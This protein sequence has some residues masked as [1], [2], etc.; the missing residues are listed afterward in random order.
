MTNKKLIQRPVAIALIRILLLSIFPLGAFA[1]EGT[2]GSTEATDAADTADTVTSVTPLNLYDSGI[3]AF[4]RY[5][6]TKWGAYQIFP[7]TSLYIDW[8]FPDGSEPYLNG[9]S[10]Y[11]DATFNYPHYMEINGEPAYCIFPGVDA[12][13]LTYSDEQALDTWEN[14]FS[15]AQRQAIGLIVALGYGA[16]D[17]TADPNDNMPSVLNWDANKTYQVQKYMATQILIWEIIVQDRSATY[18]YTLNNSRIWDSFYKA[19]SASYAWPTMLKV[20]NEIL[21]QMQRSTAVPSF[22]S[23]ASGTAPTVELQYNASA[24]QYEASLTDTNGVLASYDFSTSAA[25]ISFTKNGSILTVAAT[26]AAAQTLQKAPVTASAVGPSV[27]ADPDREAIV[28]SAAYGQP[29]VTAAETDPVTAYIRLTAEPTGTA[30]IKKVSSDGDVEGYC[31]KIYQWDEDKSWYGKTDSDGNVFVTDENY[32]AGTASYS[33]DGMT[34]GEYTFLEVLSR[35][36]AGNVFPDSWTITVTDPS[37]NTVYNKTFTS[38]IA[39]DPNGDARLGVTE[40]KIAITGLTG[41]GKMSMTIHNAP[42]T[43]ELEILKTSSSGSVSGFEFLVEGNGF[44]QTVTSDDSGKILLDGLIP[45]TYTVTEILPD[46]SPYYCTTENPQ[47]VTVEYGTLATVTFNNELKQW[48]VTVS[49]KDSATG[50][51]QAD[52]TLDGAVYG[53]YKDGI[54][55]KEYTVKNGTFTTDPWPCGT[56]YTLKEITP[57]VG[58]QLSTR[59]YKLDAYSA[60]EKSTGT[61]TTSK[62]TVFETVIKGCFQITKRTLNPVSGAT[63]PEAGAEFR[64]YLK[65]AGSYDASDDLCRGTMT[66]GEDGVAISRNLPYG[67]YIVEQTAGAEGTD[68]AA[69]FEVTVSEQGKTYEYTIDNPYWTGSVAIVKYETGTTTPLKAKFRLLDSEKNTLEQG[70]TGS[71]GRLSFSTKLVYGE[72]YYIQE[73]EA[74]AGYALDET[75]HPVSVTARNQSIRLTL[76]NGPEVGAI[77]IRKVNLQGEAVSG[78]KFCLEYSTDNKSWMP[79]SFRNAGTEVTTGGC[80]S[81][82]LD[83]GILTTD[84]DGAAVF[85][86]LQVSSGEDKVYYRLTEV[87][88]TDGSTMLAEPAFEGQLPYGVSNDITVTA[89]NSATFVLPHTGSHGMTLLRCSQLLCLSCC[90]FLLLRAKKK[91]L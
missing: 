52:A 3:S 63:A 62:V 66:T 53:L 44:S 51:A 11:G 27:A 49:K 23:N 75:L 35:K 42:E 68:M 34:D 32:E 20:R 43:G 25:G 4:S 91:A 46:D 89:V 57:P 72:I 47:T 86:G 55:I 29:V 38:E 17:F 15:E 69:N 37:G 9:Y 19:G 50:N 61:L 40:A 73:T 28:W 5:S 13:N 30:S 65:S 36:G 48:R 12:E 8:K 56:G 1:A 79:V 84:G 90:L 33:F 60:L 58:Y 16:C 54:L 18:P 2:N 39:R 21:A 88:G 7:H 83:E 76:Y 67:T 71:N 81:S 22:A 82:N 87:S 6:L 26:A 80:T 45:G 24:K 74:P 85:S 59:T 70:T 10:G 77:S 78:V 31:F 64:Y 41:G 14:G